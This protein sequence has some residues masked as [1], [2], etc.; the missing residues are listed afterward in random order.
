ML[1]LH[2]GGFTSPWWFTLILAVALVAVGYLL[3]QRRR[4]RRTLRF[5]NLDL[6]ERVAPKRQG[7]IRHLPIALMMVALL[8][9]T[10]SLTGPTADQRVPRNRATVMLTVDVSMSMKATDVSPTRLE[11]AQAAAKRFADGLTPGVNLGLVTF[12]GSATVLV[13]PTTDRTAV[14][15]AI[16]NLQLGEGTATGE[17]LLGSLRS[18]DAFSKVVSGP[19]GPP[20]A[21]VVLM[22]DGKETVFAGRAF[23][24]ADQAGKQGIPISTI[25]F[26]TV[27]GRVDIEGKS[28]P[29]PVDDKSCEEIAKRSGGEFFRAASL[30]DLD[31][32]YA[33]LGEQI[34]YETKHADAS[35][36]WLALGTIAALL[37]V[38]SG[39]VIGQRL[40]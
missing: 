30:A 16:D 8:L 23:D 18:I 28:V 34:G 33:K 11:A 2:L 15:Q 27:E 7:W 21:S 32:V 39:L 31:R 38:L 20:P 6:L 26:G 10:I 12:A 19:T 17:G 14:K 1:G 40:P 35:K 4:H 5:T 36:P 25:S 29:V 24:A 9:L 13:S 3:A 37:A 22:T